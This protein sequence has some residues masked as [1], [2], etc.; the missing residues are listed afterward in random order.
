MDKLICIY[1]HLKNCIKYAKASI[2]DEYNLLP[3]EK[4]PDYVDQI[5]DDIVLICRTCDNCED[6]KLLY[7]FIN[8]PL[9]LKK[10]AE[11]IAIGGIQI[12]EKRSKAKTA[13]LFQ[14]N[15][16]PYFNLYRLENITT[17]I[18]DRNNRHIKDVQK[19]AFS[20]ST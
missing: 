19:I 2:N 5:I 13:L 12:I 15:Y 9:I 8:D 10:G 18:I 1:T 11:P 7:E 14:A 20:L 3:F 4:A 16:T 6:N 17:I